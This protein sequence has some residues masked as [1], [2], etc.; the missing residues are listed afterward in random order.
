MSNTKFIFLL[1]F[2]LSV[3]L[4]LSAQLLP[5]SDTRKNHIYNTEF[6]AILHNG[7]P[8][9]NEN[10]PDGPLKMEF[11]MKGKLSVSSIDR[12]TKKWTP[13]NR[14]G[15]KVGIRD[16]R[17]YTLWLFSEKTLFEI[18]LEDLL[19]KCEWG[20]KI[21]FMIIDRQYQLP[22][23]EILIMSDGC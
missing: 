2:I 13:N 19:K 10:T 16:Y 12:T 1:L 18:E 4:K 22:R 20:D 9:V 17:T 3:A 14:L 11:G 15:F 7:K 8:I 5:A 21:I 23:H 6:A